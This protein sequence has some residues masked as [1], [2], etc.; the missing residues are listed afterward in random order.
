MPVSDDEIEDQIISFDE[1]A[2]FVG[3]EQNVMQTTILYLAKKGIFGIKLSNDF[4]SFDELDL[5]LPI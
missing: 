3:W 2:V 1:A 4:L 5:R